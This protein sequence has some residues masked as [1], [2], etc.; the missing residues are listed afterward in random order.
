[1]NCQLMNLSC[2]TARGYDQDRREILRKEGG[3]HY[4]RTEYC[5]KKASNSDVKIE[6]CPKCGGTCE[7][8]TYSFKTT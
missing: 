2:C 3:P 4:L 5:L 7:G 8:E 6:T 1:M